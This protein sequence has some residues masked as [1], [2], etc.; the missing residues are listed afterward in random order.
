MCIRDRG[1]PTPP[2]R[3]GV[4]GA[5]RAHEYL[6]GGGGRGEE[7]RVPEGRIIV[8]ALEGLVLDGARV[9]RAGAPIATLRELLVRGLEVVEA[10]RERGAEPLRGAHLAAED[11]KRARGESLDVYAFSVFVFAEK[12]FAVVVFGPL[13][14][15]EFERSKRSE[16]PERR[17][18]AAESVSAQ[19]QVCLLYTSPS[20]R[21]LST[22]R[23]PSSA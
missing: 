11:A 22:S 10:D 3:L 16:P 8:G 5:A 6:A 9:A 1:T 20:P 21:D 17:G 18:D 15:D 2:E 7:S 19:V 23:M 12:R 4:R 14:V 13:V